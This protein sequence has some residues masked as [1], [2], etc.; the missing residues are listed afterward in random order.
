MQ[1][2]KEASGGFFDD[3]LDGLKITAWHEGWHA[4]QLSSLRRAIGL[5][6]ALE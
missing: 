2:T 3:I 4:G 1:S 5:D 6:P